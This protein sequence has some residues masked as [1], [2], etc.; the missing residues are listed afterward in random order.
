MRQAKRTAGGLQ[1]YLVITAW[2]GVATAGA[3]VGAEP[4][5]KIGPAGEVVKV[6]T[7]FGFTEGPAWDGKEL[8]YF[9]DVANAR[10]HT[11]N[12][13][14]ETAVLLAKGTA[15]DAVLAKSGGE[16]YA[17]TKNP[18]LSL[19]WCPLPGGLKYTVPVG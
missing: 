16:A 4:I 19:I 11:V 7:G 6:A 1:R 18:E 2:L 9:T 3:A 12:A 13:A 10:I 14:G 8:L 15:I 17:S 5:P